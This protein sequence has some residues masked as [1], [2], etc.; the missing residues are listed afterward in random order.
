MG[1]AFTSQQVPAP[2]RITRP[3]ERI[4]PLLATQRRFSK[5][6]SVSK[7]I[8]AWLPFHGLPLGCI[9][10]VQSSGLACGIVFA[11]M[12]AARIPSPSG[13]M[14]Y[15]ASDR[16]FHPLGQLPYGVEPERWIHVSAR[17]SL[18]LAWTAL[19][20][21]RCPQVGAILAVVK[22]ADL[23]LCRRFQLAAE[24]SGATGFLLTDAAAK[25]ASS[26]AS[27]ITRW[28]ISSIPAP[29]GSAFGEPCWAIELA[30]CRGGRPGR[31]STVWRNGQLEPAS[32]MVAS[33]PVQ[34]VSFVPAN[35]LAG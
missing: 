19:E 5:T 1:S 35:K 3:R 33:K 15:V 28:Q 7:E 13:Q 32:G 25:P 4:E 20:A 21:L 14:V 30:Y 22:T 9:H 29:S 24:S 34:R 16:T 27:V 2:D 10:E 23:T 18:D 17:S 6:V 26:V 11:S 8:D 12:L 31:W